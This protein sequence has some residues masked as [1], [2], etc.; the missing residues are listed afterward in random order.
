MRCGVISV[1]THFAWGSKM[2]FI[3]YFAV[4]SFVAWESGSYWLRN[5]HTIIWGKVFNLFCMHTSLL[6]LQ[7]FWPAEVR[8]QQKAYSLCPHVWR[9][10]KGMDLEADVSEDVRNVRLEWPQFQLQNLE[11]CREWRNYVKAKLFVR[12]RAKWWLVTSIKKT[13]VLWLRTGRSASRHGTLL[14]SFGEKARLVWSGRGGWHVDGW[15]GISEC[16]PDGCEWGW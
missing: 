5:R 8:Q 14:T 10:N 13:F 15:A 3:R 11:H 6:N 1:I 9:E 4:C 16:T 12:S 2:R 7:F